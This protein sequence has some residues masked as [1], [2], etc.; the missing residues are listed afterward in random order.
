M[1]PKADSSSM[2]IWFSNIS[3]ILL[4][5]LN[6]LE[7]NHHHFDTKLLENVSMSLQAINCFIIISITCFP[8]LSHHTFIFVLLPLFSCLCS[9]GFVQEFIFFGLFT[10]LHFIMTVI[11][12]YSFTLWSHCTRIPAHITVCLIT[13]FY[14]DEIQLV[15]TQSMQFHFHKR[16]KK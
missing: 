5:C 8:V 15:I 12:D 4:L 1:C 13:S 14:S 16:A 6:T 2:F 9:L 10:G 7:N 11:L 3:R